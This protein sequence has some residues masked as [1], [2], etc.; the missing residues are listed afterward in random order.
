ML[1]SSQPNVTVGS[2][3]CS[4][5]SFSTNLSL[6]VRLCSLLLPVCS[7]LNP[8]T[9]SQPR[10]GW[11]L[12][13]SLALY[14]SVSLSQQYFICFSKC[15]EKEYITAVSPIYNVNRQISSLPPISFE[16]FSTRTLQYLGFT[17][18]S[19]YFEMLH[20]NYPILESHAL[21]PFTETTSNDILIQRDTV[22]VNREMRCYN[23]V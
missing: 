8:F 5:F 2:R 6:T 19:W 13:L 1:F 7:D 14:L 21:F 18:F 20:C 10:N 15:I 16:I 23:I 22:K 9:S 11:G 3:S 17:S 12:S 4:S